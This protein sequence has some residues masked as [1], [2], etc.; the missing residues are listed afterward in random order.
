MF[1]SL[2]G[3]FK[4]VIQLVSWLTFAVKHLGCFPE[5]KVAVRLQHAKWI[6]TSLVF[7]CISVELPVHLLRSINNLASDLPKKILNINALTIPV[8]IVDLG[9]IS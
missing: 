3:V 5:T 7:Y 6:S 8:V 4:E 9:D 2:Q 1:S